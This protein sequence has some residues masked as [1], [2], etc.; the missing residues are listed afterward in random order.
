MKGEKGKAKDARHKAKGV[1]LKT[2]GLIECSVNGM[3]KN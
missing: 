2:Y 3:F 1:W